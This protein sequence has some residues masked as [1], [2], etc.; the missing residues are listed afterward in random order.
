MASRA[1]NAN[2]SVGP[3]PDQRLARNLGWFSMGAGRHR[4]GVNGNKAAPRRR[5][6]HSTGAYRGRLRS[7][8]RTIED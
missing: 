7:Q 1:F 2:H 8:L 6:S 5:R 4:S 3:D